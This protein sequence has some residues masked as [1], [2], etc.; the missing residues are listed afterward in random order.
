MDPSS[1]HEREMYIVF[2]II[3]FFARHYEKHR[4]KIVEI[5][6]AEKKKENMYIISA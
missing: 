6:N 1:I 4:Q 3:Q 5:Y 2:I